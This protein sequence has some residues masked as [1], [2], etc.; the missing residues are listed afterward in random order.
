[1]SHVHSAA[2]RTE[3]AVQAADAP[4]GPASAT[5]C[6]S[7]K[8]LDLSKRSCCYRRATISSKGIDHPGREAGS[9]YETP[10]VGHRADRPTTRFRPSDG[11][12]TSHHFRRNPWRP[13]PQ[14]E[15][16]LRRSQPRPRRPG[17]AQRSSAAPSAVQGTGRGGWFRPA[18]PRRGG[19]QD[20]GLHQEEQPAEPRQQARDPGGRQAEAGFGK[21]KVTMFEMNKHL[22]QHLKK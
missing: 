6:R 19:H 15:K 14:T 4:Q 1:M 2:L 10:I 9:L 18:L 16:Q 20:V 3:R 12:T 11:K 13:R 8:Q 17:Q 5:F 7:P 21:D 22:A